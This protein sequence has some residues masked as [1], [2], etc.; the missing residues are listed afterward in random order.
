MTSCLT[1]Y[2]VTAT[3]TCGQC[4]AAN[5][6]TCALLGAAVTCVS[7]YYP[8]NGV[9]LSCASASMACASACLNL[10]Y[11]NSVSASVTSCNA[12]S[13]NA[14]SCASLSAATSC[15]SGFYLSGTATCVA[16]ASN[17]A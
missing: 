9:C 4:Q 8:L 2:Y 13:S 5:T 1:G 16:C 14:L 15:A 6:A 3:N 10:G 11:F 7:S 17:A 12:C